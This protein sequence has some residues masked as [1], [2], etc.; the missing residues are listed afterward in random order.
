[1]KLDDVALIGPQPVFTEK[2]ANSVWWRINTLAGMS[3]C[4]DAELRFGTNADYF[5]EALTIPSVWVHALSLSD[6]SGTTLSSSAASSLMKDCHIT[7]TSFIPSTSVGS[8]KEHL[9][10]NDTSAGSYSGGRQLLATV[11]VY[12]T[13]WSDV[14]HTVGPIAQGGVGEEEKKALRLCYKNSLKTATDHA[15]RTV[16]RTEGWDEGMMEAGGCCYCVAKTKGIK[17]NNKD[18][19]FP[20][21]STGIYGQC[22]SFCVRL[23]VKSEQ[24]HDIFL[25]LVVCKKVIIIFIVLHG[26]LRV[27]TQTGDFS[28]YPPEQAVHEALA[29]VREYLDA[30]H[31]K[32]PLGPLSRVNSEQVDLS[33]LVAVDTHRYTQYPDSSSLVTQIKTSFNRKITPKGMIAFLIMHNSSY[34]ASNVGKWAE[35]GDEEKYK[36][37][38]VS[39]N[40]TEKQEKGRK[41]GGWPKILKKSVEEV[42]FDS[43]TPLRCS[44]IKQ[45]SVLLRSNRDVNQGSHPS[46]IALGI[47]AGDGI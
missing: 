8:T 14:I 43:V 26:W 35:E 41:G 27:H 2:T 32:I 25:C 5:D 18:L 30:H 4:I 39:Q 10:Q 28:G 37:A 21:I 19:A 46:F 40:F 36:R 16:V 20:C 29:T 33:D 45:L 13:V 1:M 7:Q 11:A 9:W 47:R 44:I 22:L 15:A 6:F 42:M 38:A 31:D 12:D 34:E 23:L 24:M 3:V 17:T